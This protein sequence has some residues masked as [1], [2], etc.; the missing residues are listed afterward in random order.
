MQLCGMLSSRQG[1]IE[2]GKDVVRST[3]TPIET[4]LTPET[5]EG[6]PLLPPPASAITMKVFRKTENSTDSQIQ[7]APIKNP[8]KQMKR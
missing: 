6:G 2:M 4:L 5:P 1:I 3:T 7:G 8:L